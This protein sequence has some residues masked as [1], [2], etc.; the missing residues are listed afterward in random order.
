MAL[1][2]QA[3]KMEAKGFL[4]I[5]KAADIA[6]SNYTTVMRALLDGKLE[7]VEV[8]GHK[9]VSKASLLAW[10]EPRPIQPKEKG[11]GTAPRKRLHAG[12]RG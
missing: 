8:A 3:K 12:R 7:G 11:N 2:Q 4:T 5:T 9:Y 1:T 6:G 10:M